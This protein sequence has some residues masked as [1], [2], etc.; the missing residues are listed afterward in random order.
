MLSEPIRLCCCPHPHPIITTPPAAAL[1][2]AG[3]QHAGQLPQPY[4]AI[5]PLA[6]ARVLLEV[7]GL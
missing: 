4:F 1:K 5:S 6:A 2:F 3:A 7:Q